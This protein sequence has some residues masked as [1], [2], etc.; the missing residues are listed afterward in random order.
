[1]DIKITK[2]GKEFYKPIN[3]DGKSIGLRC[4]DCLNWD[5]NAITMISSSDIRDYEYDGRSYKTHWVGHFKC[6]HCGCEWEIK[7]EDH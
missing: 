3:K 4:P 5:E 1:M 6:T 2:H 7:K